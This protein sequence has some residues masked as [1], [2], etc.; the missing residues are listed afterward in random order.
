M[1]RMLQ[2]FFTPQLLKA[3]LFFHFCS[4][5]DNQ[6]RRLWSN[7]QILTSWYNQSTL[8]LPH[9]YSH[10]PIPWNSYKSWFQMSSGISALSYKASSS[11]DILKTNILCVK[12]YTKQASLECAAPNHHHLNKHALFLS[13]PS[14]PYQL[15]TVRQVPEGHLQH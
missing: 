11:P 4:N 10:R 1:E 6:W 8:P 7:E 9:L 5:K 3:P 12:I 14:Q 2:S 13:P 15:L